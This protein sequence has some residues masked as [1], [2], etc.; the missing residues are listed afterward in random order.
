M[1]GSR[2]TQAVDRQTAGRIIIIVCS[3]NNSKKHAKGEKNEGI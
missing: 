1:I 2:G 3:N